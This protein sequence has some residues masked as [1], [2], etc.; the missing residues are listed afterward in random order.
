MMRLFAAILALGLFLVPTG[1]LACK[2]PGTT[3]MFEPGTAKIAGDLGFSLES[4]ILY[5][6]SPETT[7]VRLLAVASARDDALAR[8]R[9][10]AVIERLTE[11]GVPRERITVEV[12]SSDSNIPDTGQGIYLMR[13]PYPPCRMNDPPPPPQASATPETPPWPALPPVGFI[14]GRVATDADVIAERAVFATGGIA[15][16][17]KPMD[18]PVPQYG[19]WSPGGPAHLRVVLVQA[20]HTPVG[21]IVGLRTVD[22]RSSAVALS[23]VELLG[24]QRPGEEACR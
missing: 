2:A 3:V 9:A 1:A 5:A 7:E 23:E 10:E 18:L 13:L 8:A 11:M 17:V 24:Q 15:G 19:C 12:R 4:F 16:Q 6:M 20:E 21:D 14:A 22:G